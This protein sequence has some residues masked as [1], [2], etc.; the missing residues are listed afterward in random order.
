M[1]SAK[2]WQL[3]KDDNDEKQENKMGFIFSES[4]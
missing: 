3:F 2:D 1:R 4:M